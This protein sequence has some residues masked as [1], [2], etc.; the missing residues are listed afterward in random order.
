MAKKFTIKTYQLKPTDNKLIDRIAEWY[1]EEWSIPKA[2]T[3]IRL[4]NHVNDD[5]LVQLVLKEGNS[6]IATGGLYSNTGLSIIFPHY[7]AISPWIALLYTDKK[8]RGKGHGTLLLKAL[9]EYA[10]E[11]G[12]TQVYLYTS[13]AEK[14]FK[15]NGYKQI[16]R[17]K[18]RNVDTVVMEKHLS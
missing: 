12:I 10:L 3:K 7:K 9:E 13:T 1:L 6:I 8:N 16:D 14:L 15:R 17:I 11:F 4:A 5:V 18:Y 2:R